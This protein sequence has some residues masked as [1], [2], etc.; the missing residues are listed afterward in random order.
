M[1]ILTLVSLIVIALSFPDGASA[2][3]AINGIPME[4]TGNQEFDV[5]VS[6][7]GLSASSVYYLKGAFQKAGSTNY[8][9]E[10]LNGNTWIKTGTEKT[11]QLQITTD[12]S[13]AWSGL[14]KSRADLTDTGFTGSGSYIYKVGRYTATGATVTWSSEVSVE[15]TLDSLQLIPTPT[16]SL[17][18][19]EST[20]PDESGSSETTPDNDSTSA[21]IDKKFNLSVSKTALA[22]EEEFSGT[23]TITGLVANTNYFLKGAFVKPTSTNYFGYTLVNGSWVKNGESY[24]KQ[25]PITTNGSGNYEGSIN[26]KPDQSD[27]GF[28]ESSNYTFKVGR[29]SSSGSGLTW[30][31]EITVSL[32]K[33]QTA[34]TTALSTSSTNTNPTLGSK[35]EANTSSGSNSIKASSTAKSRSTTKAFALSASDETKVLGSNDEK[36]IDTSKSANLEVKDTNSQKTNARLLLTGVLFIGIGGVLA[37][38]KYRA[39]KQL[40]IDAFD[41][42]K[43]S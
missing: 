36:S 6:L 34:G 13:G 11:S 31:N 7:S 3:M 8:F 21:P 43:P 14:I 25:F 12:A 42:E 39:N 10:T 37:F 38:R 33:I 15:I 23:V 18:V 4:V 22:G 24:S 20:P 5:A 19:V 32:T 28:V 1:K 27:T 35:A 26:F 9:G 29:Y 2:D 16:D 30:S 41:F 17:P 40:D